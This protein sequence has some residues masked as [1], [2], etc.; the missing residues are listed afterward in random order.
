MIWRR[1]DTGP[2]A[3]P[4]PPQGVRL[5]YPDSSS[6]DSLPV[7]F[8]YYQRIDGAQ[9]AVWEAIAPDSRPCIGVT[10]EHMPALTSL[11][12]AAPVAAGYDGPRERIYRDGDE[13]S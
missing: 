4:R 2:M 1:R 8:K 12:I 9:V 5:E 7:I 11:Q 6:S 10:V 13:V 3:E